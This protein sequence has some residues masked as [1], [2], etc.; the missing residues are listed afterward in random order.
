MRSGRP[1]ILVLVLSA[2]GVSA[3][4]C[5]PGTVELSACVQC[6]PTDQCER[7]GAICAEACDGGC[8]NPGYS[9]M[10]GLCRPPFCG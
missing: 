3:P 10:E 1:L 5:G 8:S 2:C 6:G 4:L 9:C 7:M